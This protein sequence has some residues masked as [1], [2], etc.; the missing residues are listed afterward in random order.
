MPKAAVAEP[1]NAQEVQATGKTFK[2]EVTVNG[3]RIQRE[4]L[5]PS[6]ETV[7]HDVLLE[8]IE[9]GILEVPA[10]YR[11]LMP[12]TGTAAWRQNREFRQDMYENPPV[13]T[14]QIGQ[15]GNG[16][17]K[18]NDDNSRTTI[19]DNQFRALRNHPEQ[20][21]VDYSGNGLVALGGCYGGGGFIDVGAD[22]GPDDRFR[23]AF[24]RDLGEAEAPKVTG[25]LRVGQGQRVVLTQPNGVRAEL[26]I[27]EGT[28]ITVEAATF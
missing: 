21:S 20:R 22:F 9:K 4:I 17:K 25:L 10:G 26:K 28:T 8:Q 2:A 27:K 3:K 14:G 7:R 1:R 24:E 18:I 19:D 13:A 23:R 16:P 12:D 6:D 5:I 15:N 11:V